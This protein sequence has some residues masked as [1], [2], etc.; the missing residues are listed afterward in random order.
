MQYKNAFLALFILLTIILSTTTIVLAVGSCAM[1]QP[2]VAAFKNRDSYWTYEFNQTFPEPNRDADPGHYDPNTALLFLDLYH[3]LYRRLEEN[4]TTMEYLGEYTEHLNGK[5]LVRLRGWKSIAYNQVYIVFGGVA[6]KSGDD[7]RC[8]H[9]NLISPYEDALEIKAHEG[10]YNAF[11]HSYKIS[12]DRFLSEH[13]EIIQDRK[14]KI[15][16]IGQSLG[17][18]QAQFSAVYMENLGYSDIRLWTFA[19]SRIGNPEMAAKVNAACSESFTFLNTDDLFCNLPFSVIPYY[20][21]REKGLRYYHAGDKI[22]WFT[23][24]EE[25]ICAN[26]SAKTYMKIFREL[27]IK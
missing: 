11:Q 20:G 23:R 3:R 17:S 10:F 25:G 9:Y 8:T 7:S 24:N 21:S 22:V 2:F 27:L 14:A 4:P 1:V 13:T 6:P 19:S 5:D 26:H 12:L 16:L 15:Y 18:I